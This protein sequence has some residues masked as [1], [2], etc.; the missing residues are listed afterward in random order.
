[1]KLIN[2]GRSDVPYAKADE[3]P[4]TFYGWCGSASDIDNDGRSTTQAFI[5]HQGGMGGVMARHT[6]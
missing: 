3:A 6:K 1:M 5:D 4:R 2:V